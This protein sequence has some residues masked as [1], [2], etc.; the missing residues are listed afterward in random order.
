M[1]LNDF[2]CPALKNESIKVGQIINLFFSMISW[3]KTVKLYMSQ[4]PRP[5][6]KPGQAKPNFWL[7]AQLTISS[8]PSCLKLAKAGHFRPS[9]SQHI[10]RPDHRFKSS[11][12]SNLFEPVNFPTQFS[13]QKEGFGCFWKYKHSLITIPFILKAFLDGL[14]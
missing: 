11:S 5:G 12:G 3:S 6:P 1:F 4:K 14:G 13:T 10:T 9:R 8:S 2:G 7:L